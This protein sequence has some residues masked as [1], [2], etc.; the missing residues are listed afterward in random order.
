MLTLVGA[1]LALLQATE[2]PPPRGLVNDFAG[3]LSAE[4]VQHM[5]RIAQDVRDKSRGE[6]A[7]VTMSGV[8][9]YAQ[10]DIALEI[11]RTWKVGPMGAVG[12]ATRNAGVVILLIPKESATDNV[13]GCRIET[14]MG[15][16][17]FITDGEAGAICREATAFFRERDYSRGLELVTL[18]VAQEFASEFGFALDTGVVAAA[19]VAPRTVPVRP[20][21]RSINPALLFLVMFVIISMLNSGRRGGRR[22]RGFPGIVVL[23]GLGGGWGGRGGGWGG[24][25]SFGGGGGGF[26]GF[27][28]GGGFSGGGG[29][30]NW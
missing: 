2:I 17:G 12:E 20:R 26:G 1:V 19:P 23:P 4:S 14:G 22:R 28:G 15:V 16:E 8:S 24:G 5:E 21:T 3:V 18:R 6:M 25:G 9:G 27:G 29:G 11:G 7:I 10:S 13:G 30:S